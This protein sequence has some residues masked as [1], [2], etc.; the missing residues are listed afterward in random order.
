LATEEN[1]EVTEEQV[2]KIAQRKAI[3]K[4]RRSKKRN[5]RS[6]DAEEDQ[7]VRA[8][9]RKKTVVSKQKAADSS[10]GKNSKPNTNSVS[11]A[12][13]HTQSLPIDYTQPIRMIPPSPQPSSPSSEGT[14]SDAS[15][16]SSE[17]IEKL[18]KLQKEQSKK[19]I[20]AKRTLKKPKHNSPEE[21]N[22]FI[23]TS[24]LDQPTN[25]TRKS[26]TILEY[27]STHL[28]GDGFTYS[29]T[30]SP[31]Q[32]HF[33][34]T[35]SDLPIDPPFPEPPIQTSPSS[36]ADIE[37]EDPP[38]YTHTPTPHHTHTHPH[39]KEKEK[40]RERKRNPCQTYSYTKRKER[41]IISEKT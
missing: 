27:L 41:K 26:S 19:K 36:L 39:E 32:F 2:A 40:G 4:E 35:S 8:L 1:E 11:S 28:S 17:L 16:D 14:S 25:T 5:E 20:P 38:T 24:I 13:P 29:N 15:T 9:K 12:Q 34:N 3:Q 10:K 33:M 21:E 37:Q 7:H 31:D 18:D 6:V 23:D 22:I 30:N